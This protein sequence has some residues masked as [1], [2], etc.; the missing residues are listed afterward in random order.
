MDERSD[1][2]LTARSRLGDKA[3]YEQLVLRHYRNL[4]GLCYAMLM[5]FNDAQD[6]CQETFLRGFEKLRD[7]RDDSLFANWITQIARRLCV[8][9]LRQRKKKQI[10]STLNEQPCPSAGDY[11]DL[12]TAIARLP[13]DYRIPLVMYYLDGH[14]ERAIASHLGTS[15]STVCR[16]IQAAKQLLHERLSE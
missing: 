5:N 2:S 8:D 15:Q 3:A 9:I 1:Q 11:S 13:D 10:V 12:T 4:L 16:R 7:L 14:D 6:V